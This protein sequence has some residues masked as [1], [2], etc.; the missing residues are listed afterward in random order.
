MHLGRSAVGA[1]AVAAALAGCGSS[2]SGDSSAAEPPSGTTVT[3]CMQ[4]N[5]FHAVITG[6]ATLDIEHATH[7]KE[8]VT[9]KWSNGAYV[10]I[11]ITPNTADA[12]GLKSLRSAVAAP[13]TKIASNPTA[14]IFSDLGHNGDTRRPLTYAGDAA[15]KAADTCVSAPEAVPPS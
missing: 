13:H 15:V 6:S 12:A 1:I 11:D 7:V 5:G 9:G 8:T 3:A 10:V 4:A 14:V 2:D